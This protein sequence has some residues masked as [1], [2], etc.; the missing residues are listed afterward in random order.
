MQTV[1]FKEDAHGELVRNMS[2]QITFVPRPLPGPL[3]LDWELSNLLNVAERALG[4]LVGVGQTLPNPRI[5]VQSFIRREAQLSSRI[6]DTHAQLS[7]LA[8]FEQTQSVEKRV[9]DVREVH[10]NERALTYGLQ[11]VQERGREIGVPLIKEMHDLLLRG[12]RGSDK[13][14]G[15]FRTIQVFIGRTERIEDARF[16]PAPPGK[17]PELMEQLAAHIGTP[18]DLPPI[19]R[20]AMV[21]YQFEAIHPFADGNGRIGRVLILLLLC[22]EGVLPLP[23][24]NPS[25]FLE[26]HREEYYHHLLHVSQRGAWTDWVKFFARGIASAAMDAVDRI[27]RLKRLQ[28]EYHKKFHTARSSALL[29]KL[30]DELFVRQAITPTRAADVL[31]VTYLAAQRSIEKL[32]AAGI[33]REITGQR[34]NRLYLAD[35][36]IKAV[37]GYDEPSGRSPGPLETTRP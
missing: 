1:D 34:R 36:I 19:G 32:V 21:H 13:Q 16:V 8:L 12:V 24:L 4:R 30:V 5:V 33:L 17:V 2:G 29:L 27:D 31:G 11:M 10:N 14:P 3:R 22:A 35:G 25:A 18:S 23:L 15:Q 6:E 9:P 7:D 26:A 20:A 28:A 37:Q